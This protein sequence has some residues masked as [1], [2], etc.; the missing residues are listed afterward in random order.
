MGFLR[1]LPQA[2]NDMAAAARMADK[3]VH[4]GLALEAL[5]QSDPLQSL[6]VA[7]S[8]DDF[9]I[10][11]NL[12]GFQSVGN[13]LPVRPGGARGAVAA[14]AAAHG[15]GEG[16]YTSGAVSGDTTTIKSQE[17]LK[18]SAKEARSSRRDHSGGSGMQKGAFFKAFGG[19]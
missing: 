4:R 7:A 8:E 15:D 10:D 19:C 9:D 5:H 2:I 1:P 12:L 3:T 11:P 16:T 14:F 6:V 18:A 13:A 17:A